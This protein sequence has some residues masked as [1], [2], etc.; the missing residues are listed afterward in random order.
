[1]DE[2]TPDEFNL[3]LLSLVEPERR[4]ERLLDSSLE[5]DRRGELD[6][7][8]DGEGFPDIWNDITKGMC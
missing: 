8:E 5:P 2:E 4:R 6:P 1:M 3:F 7:R